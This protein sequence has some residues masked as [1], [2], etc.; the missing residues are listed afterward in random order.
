MNRITT[1]MVN[2]FDF[3][4][5]INLQSKPRYSSCLKNTGQERRRFITSILKHFHPTHFVGT[6]ICTHTGQTSSEI[7]RKKSQTN[8]N[9]I[10]ESQSLQSLITCPQHH[11]FKIVIEKKGGPQ[12]VVHL[13]ALTMQEKTAWISDISQVRFFFRGIH[14]IL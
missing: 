13:Y 4:L 14:K 2:E 5:I 10:C 1:K 6:P 7:R 11:D 9:P 12:E 8:S 3:L